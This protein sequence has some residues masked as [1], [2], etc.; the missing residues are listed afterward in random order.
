MMNLFTVEGTYLCCISC[1][2]HRLE[3]WTSPGTRQMVYRAICLNRS[4]PNRFSRALGCI[5][6]DIHLDPLFQLKHDPNLHLIAHDL[7]YERA[8][9]G[10]SA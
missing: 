4:S 7:T 3:C 6:N 5:S 10:Q 8:G 9:Q 1:H 2:G